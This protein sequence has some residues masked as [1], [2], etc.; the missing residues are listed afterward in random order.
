MLTSLNDFLSLK[1]LSEVLERTHSE[2]LCSVKSFFKS[3]LTSI[4]F[5]IIIIALIAMYTRFEES[6]L[7]VFKAHFTVAFRTFIFIIFA[8]GGAIYGGI[9]SLATEKKKNGKWKIDYKKVFS[10]GI[11][12]VSLFTWDILYLYGVIPAGPVYYFG[13]GVIP[14]FLPILGFIFGNIIITSFNKIPVDESNE[15]R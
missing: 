2:V 7:N 10:W 6:I 4:I 5:Y 14:R 11:V 3:I 1:G 15:F 12:T 9:H 13:G 8:I